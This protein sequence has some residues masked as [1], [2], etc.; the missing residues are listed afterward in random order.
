LASSP[1]P[2]VC[3][4]T[5]RSYW[6]LISG[7][8][9]LVFVRHA[10]PA[11]SVDGLSQVDPELTPLGRFQARALAQRLEA[12]QQAPAEIL[13]SPAMR[14]QQTAAPLADSLALTPT[15]VSDL[16]EIRMPD[17]SGKLEEEV[18]RIF[19]DSRSRPPEDWWEGL[20][21][22]E[23]FRSFHDR[24][25]GVM[26]RILAERSVTPDP[27]KH[28]QLWRVEADPR[29]VVIVAHGGTNAVALGWLL[30]VAPTPWEWER[31][32]LG[33]ASIARVRAIPLA[34]GHVF[35]LR[36]FNDREHLEPSMRTR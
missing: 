20:T 25:T 2:R 8:M 10:Q 32:I 14:A 12:D 31:F 11:W 18:Q 13:V 23:S 5:Y 36:T 4:Q 33:H 1:A 7:P 30:G 3:D 28:R 9:E 29:R 15:T 6:A 34:G 35:S 16:V 17:W 21:D 27:S 22:G 26:T 24:V 19:R